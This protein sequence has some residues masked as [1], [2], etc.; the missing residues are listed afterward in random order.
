MSAILWREDEKTDSEEEDYENDIVSELA[1]NTDTVNDISNYNIVIYNTK[2]LILLPV[3]SYEE[4]E[5]YWGV[6]YYDYKTQMVIDGKV[7]AVKCHNEFMIDHNSRELVYRGEM[8]VTTKENKKKNYQYYITNIE[9]IRDKSNENL[10]R[11]HYELL[12]KRVLRKYL[13][14]PTK[15]EILKRELEHRNKL[16]VEIDKVLNDLPSLLYQCA[17]KGLIDFYVNFRNVCEKNITGYGALPRIDKCP[18]G[19]GKIREKFDDYVYYLFEELY[20]KHID[21]GDNPHLWVGAR[22]MEQLKKIY[23]H[24]TMNCEPCAPEMYVPRIRIL[25]DIDLSAAGIMR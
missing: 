18:C 22:V 4:C 5:S 17:D 2:L 19:D 11:I 10:D 25:F 14:V 8:S 9:Y 13:N 12:R 16:R 20:H 21:E 23:P 1:N 6:D 15:D 24:L 7:D 3:S